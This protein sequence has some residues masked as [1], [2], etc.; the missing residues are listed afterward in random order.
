MFSTGTMGELT[1][2]LTADGREIGDGKA[3]AVTRRMQELHRE[4]AFA[5]GENVPFAEP[6]NG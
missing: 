6:N 4:Y 1:P 2:I 3:G 5:N